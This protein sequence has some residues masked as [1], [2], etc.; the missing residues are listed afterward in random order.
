MGSYSCPW[1]KLDAKLGSFERDLHLRSFLAHTQNASRLALVRECLLVLFFAVALLQAHFEA[2]HI[3]MYEAVP[4]HHAADAE[5]ENSFDEARHG[6]HHHDGAHDEGSSTCHSSVGLCHCFIHQSE[7][8]SRVYSFTL[9]LD[10][11]GLRRAPFT[12]PPM[13]LA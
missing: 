4:N 6:H 11:S 13:P 1:R 8:N 5:G 9:A 10:F 7:C 12:P 2:P 3:G